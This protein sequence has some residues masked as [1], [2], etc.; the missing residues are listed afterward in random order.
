[1]KDPSP[2]QIAN[3]GFTLEVASSYYRMIT[4]ENFKHIEELVAEAD[5]SQILEIIDLV[6]GYETFIAKIRPL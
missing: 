3:F 1:M 2:G 6:L 4:T 5:W